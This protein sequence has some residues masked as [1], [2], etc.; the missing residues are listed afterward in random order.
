VAET[1]LHLLVLGEIVRVAE[2]HGTFK[3]EREGKLGR[4]LQDRFGPV[5]IGRQHLPCDLKRGQ[6][7]RR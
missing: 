1:R 5:D 4:E 2:E 3:L 7:R 6:L